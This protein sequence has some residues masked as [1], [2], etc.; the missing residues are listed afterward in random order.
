MHA[1]SRR[2]SRRRAFTLL[3]LLLALALLALVTGLF[4]TGGRELLRAR[5][6]GA[7][8][9]FWQAVQAARQQAIQSETTVTLRYDARAGRIVWGDVGEPHGLDLPARNLE[10]LREGVRD[11]VLIGGRLVD[12]ATLPA[13]RFHPDGTIDR[14][15]VQ[16]TDQEGRVVQLEL[17]PWTAAPVVRPAS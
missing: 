11:T 7:V 8:D 1:Y 5:E 13:V 9:V 12:T 2:A 15:R 6:P 10:F 3:E 4:I 17:D 14:F 16:L